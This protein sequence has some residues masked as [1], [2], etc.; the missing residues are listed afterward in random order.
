MGSP[1]RALQLLLCEDW[2]QAQALAEDLNHCNQ[3]RQAAEQKILE[4]VQARLAADPSL[5]RDPVLLLW[6]EDYHPGVIGI[7]ASR[8]VEKY[9]RPAI[10]VSIQNGEGRGSGR[11]VA[12]FNLH[13]AISACGD[14]LIR[15]GGH[16]L[17]AGLS[18]EPARLP[19]LRRRL[20][21][22]A[23]A[24][25]PVPPAPTL[26]LDLAVRLDEI[27]V[28]DVES[29]SWL[30]PC[31]AGNPAPLFLVRDAQVEAVYP[32][33]DGRHSRLRLRQGTGTLYAV[34]FGYSPAQLPCRAG[35]EGGR[36]PVPERL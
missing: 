10:L 3:E 24:R 23:R 6:G 5:L 25:C 18:V 16:A 7:V 1:A 13:A 9:G 11:S 22:W 31:G 15:Y 21:D 29:L 35:R 20:N 19:E 26:A 34:Y 8:L 36:G 14:L 32:V 2:E 12:G 30:A 4:E 28:E 27:T 17:A 33:G